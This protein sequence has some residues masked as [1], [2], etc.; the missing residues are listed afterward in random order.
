MLYYG[1]DWL[2]I[3][4]AFPLK[5]IFDETYF[6][7][8]NDISNLNDILNTRKSFDPIVVCLPDNMSDSDIELTLNDIL[9][10]TIYTEYEYIYHY[11]TQAYLLK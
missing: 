4:T 5:F 3:Y 6:F 10:N 1:E 7:D 2:D 8:P 11:Y 9:N